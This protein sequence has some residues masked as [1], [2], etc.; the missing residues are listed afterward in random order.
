[1]TNLDGMMLKLSYDKLAVAVGS[2]A[3]TFGIPGVQEQALFR[4]DA[5]DSAKLHAW[6][7]SNLEKAAAL[8][9]QGEKYPAEINILMKVAVVGV[10]I[11]SKKKLGRPLMIRQTFVN[12]HL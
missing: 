5:K 10:G 6:L 7:L 11:T 1:M 4:K 8:S 9:H 3:N 12:T 2:Q